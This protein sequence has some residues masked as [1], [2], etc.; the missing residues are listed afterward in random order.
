MTH[1]ENDEHI[2]PVGNVI[3][4]FSEHWGEGLLEGYGPLTA[5][6]PRHWSS[7]ESFC[8]HMHSMINQHVLSTRGLLSATFHGKPISALNLVLP[9]HLCQDHTD[10][11]QQILVLLTSCSTR[12]NNDYQHLLPADAN[13][14]ACVGERQHSHKL[15]HQRGLLVRLCSNVGNPDE[16]REE[17]AVGAQGVE[18][19]FQTAEARV[20]LSALRRRVP[21]QGAPCCSLTCLA[22]HQVS[23]RSTRLLTPAQDSERFRE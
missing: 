14:P 12:A 13:P 16:A 18:V 3:E 8:S 5:G 11:S 10:F 9:Q 21:T 6:L 7:Y 1:L 17:L 15:H 2:S 23:L 4:Q 19:G 22:L 20:T